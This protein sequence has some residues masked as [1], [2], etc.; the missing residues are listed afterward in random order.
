M[1][2]PTSRKSCVY[3][4]DY[5]ILTSHPNPTINNWLAADPTNRSI[6]IY[7]DLPFDTFRIYVADYPN[8][9]RTIFST[10]KPN[11]LDAAIEPIILRPIKKRSTPRP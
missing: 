3:P 1:K 6:T 4:T 9:E 7:Y 8:S 5:R 10:T 11:E 2:Q